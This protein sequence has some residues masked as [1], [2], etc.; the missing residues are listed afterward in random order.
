MFEVYYDE[1]KEPVPCDTF[2]E[3][4][5]TAIKLNGWFHDGNKIQFGWEWASD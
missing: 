4:I 5:A 1:D 3:A 2:E